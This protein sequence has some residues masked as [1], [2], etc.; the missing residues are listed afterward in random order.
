MRQPPVYRHPPT[1][2]SSE[3]GAGRFLR[4]TLGNL[5][6]GALFWCAAIATF[7]L[8]WLILRQG[9][10]L[11][12]V[13]AVYFVLMWA[14][15][16]YLALPRLHLA[17]TSIY[18]PHYFIGRTRTGDGLLGDP[19][20]LALDAT[21]A[22][23]H[24]VMRRAGW[25]MADPINLTSSV[26]IAV[27]SVAGKSYP[28]APVSSLY[29]FER[30]QDF[31]Y[32]MEVEGNPA[33][34]HHVRFWKCPDGWL[35]PGG[36]RVEWLAAGTY[37][38][39]V[40]FS[41]FTLQITHKIDE[42][43]DIE[44]D[45]IVDSVLYASPEAALKVIENFSTGYHSRN[46]GGDVVRTDGHLPV[47]QLHDVEPSPEQG[48]SVAPDPVADASEVAKRPLSVLVGVAISVVLLVWEI[49]AVFVEPST[50]V[51]AETVALSPDEA[52]VLLLVL[53]AVMIGL[54]A[55]NV[56]VAWLTYRGRTWARRWLVLGSTLSVFVGLQHLSTT[57][58]ASGFVPTMIQTGLGVLSIYALTGP[59]ARDWGRNQ[60]R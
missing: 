14:I 46:G 40:G 53:V 1:K 60:L 31:A 48:L 8:A 50:D 42:D 56:I 21:E 47:L 45:F 32:Q 15:T 26:R 36:E 55:F 58:H 12:W 20:N 5:L 52:K 25:T 9:L 43:I 41:L 11:S 44:R 59:S 22:Q 33:Q 34:R 51:R 39:A 28:E 19:V 3:P 23:I 57:L 4:R 7:V 27:G 6:D 38:R 54:A 16:A 30:K 24:E 2:T 29:L 37:D 13:L 17:L 35:L 10:R 18:V 49:V